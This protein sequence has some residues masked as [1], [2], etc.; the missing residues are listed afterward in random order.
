MSNAGHHGSLCWSAYRYVL[1]NGRNTMSRLVWLFLVLASFCLALYQIQDRIDYFLQYPTSTSVELVDSK[2][3]RFP[4]VTICNENRV[5]K[6]AAEEH[7]ISSFRFFLSEL[8]TNVR[9]MRVDDIEHANN[10][11]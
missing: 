6:S 10:M 5:L 8:I 7:R 1:D 9:S 11:K 4:Q 2:Q 3:F